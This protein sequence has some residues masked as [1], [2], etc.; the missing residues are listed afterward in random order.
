L[1]ATCHV[2][3]DVL[4]K[5]LA[6]EQGAFFEGKSR[7]SE[8]PLADGAQGHRAPPP[9]AQPATAQPAAVQQDQDPVV[10]ING[11]EED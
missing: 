1:Q 4:H 9:P 11:S 3:G 8:E 2:E 5:S 7:R 10:I 6:I